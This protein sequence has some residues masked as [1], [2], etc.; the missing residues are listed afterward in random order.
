ML[1]L[2]IYL[3]VFCEGE[4]SWFLSKSFL[5]YLK[6]RLT[7]AARIEGLFIHLIEVTIILNL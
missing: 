4:T 5:G 3:V 7:K 1:G 6:F 2:N